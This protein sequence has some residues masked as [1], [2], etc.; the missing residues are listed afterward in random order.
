M[1]PKFG[2]G[3]HKHRLCIVL[4]SGGHTTEM[5]RMLQGVALDAF[6]P[7][8][9]V[10]ATSDSH[11]EAKMN[12]FE[13]SIN[14]QFD[15]VRIPRS[16]EVNQSWT[17]SVVTTMA[18]SIAS[19]QLVISHQ[20]EVLLCNGPG[21]CVPLAVFA[22]LLTRLRLAKPCKVIYIESFARVRRLSLSGL[23]LHRIVDQFVVQWPQLKTR[24]PHAVY[25][26]RLV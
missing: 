3:K 22:V 24:Y 9:Y 1:R 21:T 18:A 16:R 11:S 23:L 12:E 17:S 8:L 4:G 19:L 5:F 14:R 13:S 7:R 25:K 6:E 26:G 10:I 15:S 20:P 2:D